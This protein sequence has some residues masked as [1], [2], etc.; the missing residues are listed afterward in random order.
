[1]R[2]W[3]GIAITAVLFVI[4]PIASFAQGLSPHL[5]VNVHRLN[6]RNGP[7]VSFDIMTSVGGGTV[8]PVT[9]IDSGRIWFQVTSPAGAGWVNATYAVDR[10]DFSG[11][12]IINRQTVEAPAIGF[13]TPRL[14]INTAYLNVRSGPG[15]S[16]DILGTVSGLDELVVVSVDSGRLWY[17]VNTGVGTG[18]VNSSYTVRRGNFSGIGTT[19]MDTVVAP[20]IA[21]GTPHL[22]V[23]T[24]YLNVR[25]G[26]GIS[27]A[28]V[29]TV[30]GG[31]ELPVT[32]ISA[33]NPRW[34]Q[35]TSAAGPGWV[36][37]YYTIKRGDFSRVQQAQGGTV[38]AT[39]S[40][41]LTGP[42]PRA[43]ANTG[44]LNI[45][46]GPGA[47]HSIITSVPGGTTLAVLGLSSNRN[48]YQ[49]VGSFGQG[50]LNNDYVVFR[51]EFSLVPVIG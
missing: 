24:A 41:E 30:S 42:T 35:V 38:R 43:I 6:V 32:A 33:D 36:N 5:V 47:T 11:V 20:T 29:T 25:S 48:W 31:T 14:V 40:V 28:I 26:P 39:P 10:G 37:S 13:H 9:G 44:R 50:W 2:V 7:G 22:V 15:V 51:G 46:T 18:W 17:Q 16:Y 27:H 23:N 19:T 45:R 1:M 8:L 4:F 21:F 49:V 3:C 34:H 12:P